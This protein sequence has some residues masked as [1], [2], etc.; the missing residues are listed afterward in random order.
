MSTNKLL[1]LFLHKENQTI[2][3]HLIRK[4]PLF[5]VAVQCI[6]I[7]PEWWF[8]EN[9]EE[10][11]DFLSNP[12]NLNKLSR[13]IQLNKYCLMFL[14]KK[15]ESIVSAHHA[16]TQP[17]NPMQPVET[18]VSTD[19]AD[20]ASL[21]YENVKLPEYD[22]PAVYTSGQPA[23]SPNEFS[24]EKQKK[25]KEQQTIKEFEKLKEKYN[26]LY[27]RQPQHQVNFSEQ[28]EKPNPED[29]SSLLK[30]QEDMRKNDVVYQT[31]PPNMNAEEFKKKTEEYFAAP[32]K[33][34]KS[35]DERIEMLN[36]LLEA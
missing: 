9:M 8:R 35:K 26:G 18:I 28:I 16:S 29:M 11:Y 13:L 12:V 3:W 31:P 22:R 20:P 23:I 32:Q 15:L 34:G 10:C 17:C 33:N 1:F 24:P 36:S 7:S 25:E 4:H 30:M 6:D 2:L 27:S 14:I 21:Q 5:N 19:I